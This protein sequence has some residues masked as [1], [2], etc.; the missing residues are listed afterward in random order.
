MKSKLKIATVVGARPQFI[1][2][3][4]V[5]RIIRDHFSSQIEEEIIHTGQHYD[6]GMSDLFFEQLDIPKPA[7]HLGIGSSSH[8]SQTGEMLIKLEQ[9]FQSRK[10]DAIMVYGDTNSTLAGA[11]AAV[12]IHIPI[13]HVESGLRSYLTAMPEEVNRVCTDHVSSLMS[14]PNQTAITNLKK[15]GITDQIGACSADNPWVRFH[16]DVMYDNILFL[17][18]KFGNHCA[19]MDQF[20]M[21]ENG[22]LL[23]TI[24]RPSNTDSRETLQK[25]FSGLQDL[26]SQNNLKVF[27]PLHPRTLKLAESNLDTTFWNSFKSDK[28]IIIHDPI[29]IIEI[30]QLVGQSKMVITDSGGLQKEAVFLDKPCIILRD[31]T[32]W[33]ELLDCGWGKTVG[34]DPEKLTSA[35][36][37]LSQLTGSAP[38]LY[39]DGDAAQKLCADIL[40]AFS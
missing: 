13:I 21:E 18:D 19:L 24:H 23:A 25:L 11:L 6:H 29:G 40:K 35:F 2:A 4:V 16:G 10:P 34:S 17:R 3:G 20:G 27:L 28:N 37:E 32:E 36:N 15:E 30:G 1:K 7:A 8:G 33:V 12:K 5:N 38:P 31:R 9:E 26:A 22:F 14:C 39:G